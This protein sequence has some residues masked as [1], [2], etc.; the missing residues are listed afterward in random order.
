MFSGKTTNFIYSLKNDEIHNIVKV[1]F[2]NVKEFKYTTQKDSG[3]V[4]I[5]FNTKDGK[6][7]AIVVDDSLN[8]IAKDKLA[9]DKNDYLLTYLPNSMKVHMYLFDLYKQYNKKD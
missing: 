5:D 7:S 2:P 8:V 9:L 6:S 1:A 4:V 3:R